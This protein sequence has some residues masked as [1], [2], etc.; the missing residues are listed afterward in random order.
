MIFIERTS[1]TENKRE[2]LLQLQCSWWGINM[3]INSDQELLEFKHHHTLFIYL[4]YLLQSGRA[5]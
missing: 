3:I 2:G 4:C 1:C 5:Y